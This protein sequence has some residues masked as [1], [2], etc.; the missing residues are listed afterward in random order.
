MNS[1]LDLLVEVLVHAISSL[2]SFEF[3]PCFVNTRSYSRS[4]SDF[5]PSPPTTCVALVILLV[6]RTTISLYR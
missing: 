6:H 3:P 2:F 4:H 1:T 5:E